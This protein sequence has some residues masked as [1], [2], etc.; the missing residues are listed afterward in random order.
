I[1]KYV[2]APGPAL[3]IDPLPCTFDRAVKMIADISTGNVFFWINND[4]GANYDSG[5]L[6]CGINAGAEGKNLVMDM[7]GTDVM[8]STL[9]GPYP[10]HIEMTFWKVGSTLQFRG[11][12]LVCRNG[13]N[14]TFDTFGGVYNVAGPYTRFDFKNGPMQPMGGEFQF[15]ESVYAF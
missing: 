14:L 4:L 10:V 13:T 9:T 3:T 6:S 12:S 8:I 1:G 7:A 2:P 11:E 5:K 15:F